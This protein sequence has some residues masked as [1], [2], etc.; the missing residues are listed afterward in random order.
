MT[1][2]GKALDP[3][4]EREIGI[5]RERNGFGKLLG[6]RRWRGASVSVRPRLIGMED[7]EEAATMQLRNRGMP[8]SSN[9]PR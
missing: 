2:R 4:P 1:R 5:P 3:R 8:W 6:G 7:E 9:T